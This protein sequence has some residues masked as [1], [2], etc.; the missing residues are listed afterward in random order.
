MFTE[1]QNTEIHNNK[2]IVGGNNTY[3]IYGKTI[4][5]GYKWKDKSRK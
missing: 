1:D 2:N 4:K 5:Y 3:G